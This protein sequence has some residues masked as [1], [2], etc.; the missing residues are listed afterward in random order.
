MMHAH[1]EIKAHTMIVVERPIL[2]EIIGAMILPA[3]LAT[4]VPITATRASDK[5][6][7]LDIAIVIING[8]ITRYAAEEAKMDMQI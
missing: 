5:D 7:P 1:A 6:M 8:T 3:E 2:S 4:P